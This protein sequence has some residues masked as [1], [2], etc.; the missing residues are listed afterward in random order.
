M[1]SQRTGRATHNAARRLPAGVEGFRESAL[2]EGRRRRQAGRLDPA[3]RVRSLG[4]RDLGD[5]S[6]ILKAQSAD[7]ARAERRDGGQCEHLR[8]RQGALRPRQDH[9]AD[10]AIARRMGCGSAELSGAGL[11]RA[12]HAY[13]LQ[14]A[15]RAFRGDAYGD[16]GKEPHAVLPRTD[17]IPRRGTAA[18]AE[19]TRM[20]ADRYGRIGA[21]WEPVFPRDKRAGVC[22]EIML[23]RRLCQSRRSATVSTTWSAPFL[24]ISVARGR[25][26]RMLSSRLARLVR[27]QIAIA[28]AVASSSDNSA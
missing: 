23:Q 21:K 20:I 19:V 6:R 1:D 16:D 5:R 2:A 18:G 3:R 13:A 22:A 28:V 26:G 11:F 15:D 12:A 10:A 8:R 25:V 24:R 4:V 7:A 17:G 14:A 9:G 27:S